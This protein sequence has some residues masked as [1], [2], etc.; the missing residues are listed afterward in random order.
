[1]L[2]ALGITAFVAA[3]YPPIGRKESLF[4]EFIQ[5]AG[6]WSADAVY[7]APQ[8]GDYFVEI[9]SVDARAGWSLAYEPF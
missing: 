3:I 2:D 4:T 8:T 6:P 1:M 7:E 5:Q 9:S